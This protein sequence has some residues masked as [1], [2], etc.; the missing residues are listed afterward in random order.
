MLKV[1]RKYYTIF[2]E[3]LEQKNSLLEYFSQLNVENWVEFFEDYYNRETKY[4]TRIIVP[5]KG[6]DVY[7]YSLVLLDDVDT[8]TRAL[9]AKANNSLLANYFNE[10][11]WDLISEL[12]N[13][14]R[15]LE[16]N[17]SAN[18]LIDI[19]SNESIEDE[20]REHAAI[21]LS[22]VHENTLTPF[23]DSLN[24]KKDAFLIPSYISFF[25]KT[26]PIKGLSK[27]LL[28]KDEP[29][30]IE[31]Y[32]TP[33]FYSLLQVGNSLSDIEK[34]QELSVKLPIWA[35]NFINGIFEDYPELDTLQEKIEKPNERILKNIGLSSLVWDDLTVQ[36]EDL[37]IRNSLELLIDKIKKRPDLLKVVN[38]Q[39]YSVISP[40]YIDSMTDVIT[41]LQTTIYSN[42]SGNY[43][44]PPKEPVFDI[45]ENSIYYD[46]PTI[47]LYP[48]FLDTD[49][50]E[51]AGVIPYAK[52]TS[53]AIVIHKDNTQ[54]KEWLKLRA[55]VQ[56][57]NSLPENQ[58]READLL[59][60]KAESKKWL[61]GLVEDIY[62]NSGQ[63]HTIRGYV[64]HSIIKQFV[65]NNI[66]N[67]EALGQV[68]KAPTDLSIL[69]EKLQFF[70]SLGVRE[71]IDKNS[72][73]LLDPS[74]AFKETD[75]GQ[76]FM[77]D[78]QQNFRVI[79][80]KHGLE[81][82]VGIGFSLFAL[83][84]LL[85]KGNW[86]VL[87]DLVLNKLSDQ[88]EKFFKV[89]IELLPTQSTTITIQELEPVIA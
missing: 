7:S 59:V 44:E 22:V 24:L 12:F 40:D 75:N 76:K 30:D 83:P 50:T 31:A 64:F 81:I 86:K 69:K 35:T 51:K 8:S 77:P 88:R 74:D 21:T 37:T 55:T 5:P 20:V 71:S 10:S 72:I 60:T 14:V 26:N 66:E 78:L 43:N 52:Q 57:E 84:R 11:K 61:K 48:Y 87:K 67:D 82:P 16:L 53:L 80:V 39:K 32:E 54:Y 27:L 85:E 6:E 9:I 41:E 15:Y 34:Y 46:N 79:T 23:W 19:I 42:V 58:E 29:D 36:E 18:I 65:I 38:Q 4:L 45:P 62:N 68:L 1:E 13:T 70:R 73:L 89:G 17:I 25:E 33:V 3:Q 63:I 49:R 47:F 28:I 56:N 2:K